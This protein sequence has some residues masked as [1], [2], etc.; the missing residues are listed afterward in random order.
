MN[1]MFSAIPDFYELDAN[2]TPPETCPYGG[3]VTRHGLIPLGAKPPS[4][5]NHWFREMIINSVFVLVLIMNVSSLHLDN[6]ASKELNLRN[7]T[8]RD[9]LTGD[10]DTAS[11]SHRASN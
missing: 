5:E 7:W 6:N 9:V 1:Y 3:H 11:H 4:T 10:I 8:S 2:S